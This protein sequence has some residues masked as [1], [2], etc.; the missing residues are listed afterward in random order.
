MFFTFQGDTGTNTNY[1]Q[2]VTTTYYAAYHNEDGST[3]AL[4]YVTMI[5][6]KVQI[7]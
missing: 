4:Q 3:A 5:Y 2:T 6:L 1:N 7:L